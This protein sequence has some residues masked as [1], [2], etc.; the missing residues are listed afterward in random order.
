MLH[1]LPTMLPR[2]QGT[3]QTPKDVYQ[4]AVFD[5]AY[6]NAS[7]CP[8]GL[9]GTANGT[10]CQLFGEY[11]LELAGFNSVPVYAGMNERCPAQWPDYERCPAATPQC[12]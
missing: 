11:R 3:E 8:S 1:A 10:Y 12:C 5:P 9:T 4:M 2:M 7:N 6:F